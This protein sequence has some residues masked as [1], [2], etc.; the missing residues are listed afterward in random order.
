MSDKA[1]QSSVQA[2]ID[3]V[4]SGVARVLLQDPDGEWRGHSL[5]A[6]SLPKEAR[7]G[8]WLEIQFKII[9]PPAGQT[10]PKLRDKLSRDDKGGDLVL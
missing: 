5:P 9:A 2:Y 8:S 4:E 3:A 7:E 6:A 10:G 1:T